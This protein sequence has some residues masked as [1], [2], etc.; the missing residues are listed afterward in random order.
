MTMLSTFSTEFAEAFAEAA[1]AAGLRV[2]ATVRP[3]SCV[4]RPFSIMVAIERPDAFAVGNAQS[5]EW[6]IE[7]VTSDAPDLSE[8]DEVEID[9]VRFRV[10]R[11]P[12][13]AEGGVGGIDG[14]FM[15]AALTTVEDCT[16]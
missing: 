7:Y 16:R 13:V 3:V 8:G 1:D 11:P 5:T 6:G 4:G 9:E 14:T 2:A 15:R 12:V 10:R